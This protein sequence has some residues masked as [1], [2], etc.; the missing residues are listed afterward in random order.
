MNL[1]NLS[2]IAQKPL[3]NLKKDTK[4]MKQN[5]ILIGIIKSS[6]KKVSKKSLSN[7]E[8]LHT[9]ITEIEGIMNSHPLTYLSQEK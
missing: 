1:Q 3:K 4:D 8:E 2:V 7:Y 5:F 6:L 9:V